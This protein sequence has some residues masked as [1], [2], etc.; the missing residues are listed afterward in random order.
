MMRIVGMVPEE[1]QSGGGG[2]DQQGAG[3]VGQSHNNYHC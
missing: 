3:C 2:P 1:A